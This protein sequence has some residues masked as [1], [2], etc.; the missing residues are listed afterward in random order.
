MVNSILFN[1]KGKQYNT[2]RQQTEEN[3]IVTSYCGINEELTDSLLSNIIVRLE[4]T[5][6]PLKQT[7]HLSLEE[8]FFLNYAIGC[9]KIM[10]FD[11]VELSGCKLWQKFHVVEPNFFKRYAV[12]HYYRSKGWII[13][14][15]LKFGGDYLLYKDGPTYNHASYLVKILQQEGQLQWKEFI[16]I[17]RLV[18][19]FNKVCK[20]FFV[21]IRNNVTDFFEMFYNNFFFH[22][23]LL[24]CNIL[25]S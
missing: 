2:A 5:P 20:T 22:F 9:L 8:S 17:N 11:N 21:I 23:Y 3:V 1:R 16:A 12:Y 18:E 15:G 6:F 13:K 4:K 25:F 19:T 14:S 7:L 24:G 10:D